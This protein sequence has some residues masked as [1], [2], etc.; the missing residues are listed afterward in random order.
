MLRRALS[1]V[2]RPRRMPLG[3]S[4]ALTC[5]S[6]GTCRFIAR[7]PQVALAAFSTI[8]VFIGLGML[9]ASPPDWAGLAF[10]LAGF[11]FFVRALRSP[12]VLADGSRVTT[13]SI[14]R[15]RHYPL[16]ELTSVEVAVGRT[17]FTGLA[18]EYLI[19]RCADGRV[20][21]FKELNCARPKD[22]EGESL[23]RNAARC[24]SD[25]LSAT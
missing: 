24:I 23:V 2:R 12:A 14:I 4:T 19:F 20:T 18:R 25:L 1:S 9:T 10:A 11:V 3:D 6:Q 22:P 8:V 21:G 13:R 17:G 15:T 16:T 5:R 7:P